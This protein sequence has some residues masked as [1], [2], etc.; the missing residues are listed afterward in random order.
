MDEGLPQDWEGECRGARQREKLAVVAQGDVEPGLRGETTW[1]QMP[2][3]A[4]RGQATSP[5]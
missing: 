4:P 5:C 3:L 2:A 1:A